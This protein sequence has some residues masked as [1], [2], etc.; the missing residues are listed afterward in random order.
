MARKTNKITTGVK[1]QLTPEQQK[2]IDA[3]IA[4][5][6]AI[7]LLAAQLGIEVARLEV[8][9]WAL[10]HQWYPECAN[11]RCSLEF[12]KG[13]VEVGSPAERDDVA[14]TVSA[15]MEKYVPFTPVGP[16]PHTGDISEMI[17]AI[18]GEQMRRNGVAQED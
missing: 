6:R 1:I 9:S 15:M 14:T 17:A 18:M 4:T 8:E 16:I 5:S 10:I 11:F 7:T 2:H 13:I 12:A 3:Y